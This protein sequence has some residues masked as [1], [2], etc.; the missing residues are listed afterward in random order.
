MGRARSQS[1]FS[2]I[3]TLVIILVLAILVGIAIPVFLA[4]REKARV[5]ATQRGLKDAAVAADGFAAGNGGSYAGL[6]DD[7][8]AKLVAE[9]FRGSAGLEIGVTGEQSKY[10]VKI[11]NTLL[12]SPHPWW[13]GTI[14]PREGAPQEADTCDETATPS[15]LQS[16]LNL[17]QDPLDPLL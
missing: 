13:E 6:N 5:A 3:E 9:G 8:P 16:L 2:L 4:Q 10:C 15:T 17:L 7:G 12:P 11:R 14:E 1:G